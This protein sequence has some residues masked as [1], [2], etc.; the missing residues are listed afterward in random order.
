MRAGE[1]GVID[2]DPELDS[3][4]LLDVFLHEVAHLRLHMATLPDESRGPVGAAYK[5]ESQV[6]RLAYSIREREAAELAR[7]WS[8]EIARAHPRGRGPVEEAFLTVLR[9]TS[10]K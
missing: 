7:R 2:L 5:A 6:E 10:G 3:Q 9:M 4:E 8:V 1:V